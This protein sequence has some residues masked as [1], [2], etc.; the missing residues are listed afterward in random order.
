MPYDAEFHDRRP[1]RREPSPLTG[2]G[3]LLWLCAFFGAIFLANF[4]LTFSALRTLPGGV[5]A[6]SYDASQTWNQ[7]I[8]AARAQTERGWTAEASVRAEGD[9][10]RVAFTPADRE[11]ALV[12]G[13]S[14]EALL[15]HPS[16]KR[17]D[18]RVT[19]V[20]KDGGYEAVIPAAT[21]GDWTLQIE[22]RRDGALLYTTR[23]HVAL[24]RGPPAEATK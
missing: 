7:R 22:A 2:R 11:G 24:R 5:L 19:L 14:V 9:G 13:L 16:D 10:A 17:L 3:V 12:P 23:N 18:R 4:A 8:A 15:E 1:E 20:A 6:N 21:A